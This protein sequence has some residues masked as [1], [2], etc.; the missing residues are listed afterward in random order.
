M[1]RFF[2]DHQVEQVIVSD[3]SVRWQRRLAPAILFGGVAI[4][5]VVILIALTRASLRGTGSSL[6][7]GQGKAAH[8]QVVDGLT[9]TPLRDLSNGS[10][11]ALALYVNG[12]AQPVPAGIGMVLPPGP[13]SQA[14]ASN[15]FEQCAYPL[16]TE[17]PDGIVQMGS[18]PPGSF[19][20]GQFFDLWG[21]PLSRTQFAGYRAGASHPLTFVVLDAQGRTTTSTGNPRKIPLL[22]H[23]TVVVLYSSAGVTPQPKKGWGTS[24]TL[25]QTTGQPSATRL[26]RP[27]VRRGALSH[28]KQGRA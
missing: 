21:Q 24:T 4:V 28:A 22:P 6:R 16:R 15:G 7:L 17:R 10:E 3:A 27:T 1:S 14:Q 11:A 12:R 19:T 8:G 5:A 25:T 18:A 26:P 2:R 20:L 23:T 13:S 9:C